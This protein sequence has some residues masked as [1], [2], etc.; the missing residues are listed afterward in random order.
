MEENPGFGTSSQVKLPEMHLTTDVTFEFNGM[1]YF[2]TLMQ[3]YGLFF[4]F[5]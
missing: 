5:Q 3:R 1:D 4:T 2:A